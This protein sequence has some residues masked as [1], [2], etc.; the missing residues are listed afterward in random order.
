M[1]EGATPPVT[2]VMLDEQHGE[3]IGSRTATS[4]RAG[5]GRPVTDR[6]PLGAITLV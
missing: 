3:Y 6:T 5:D 1:V 2:L 4:A